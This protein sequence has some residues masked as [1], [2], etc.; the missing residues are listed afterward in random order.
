MIIFV[1]EKQ[2]LNHL[3]Y[4]LMVIKGFRLGAVVVSMLILCGLHVSARQLTEQEAMSVAGDFQ[5]S[6]GAFRHQMP[7]GA[8]PSLR[9]AYKAVDKLTSK[10]SFYVFDRGESDGFVIVSGDD[11]LRDVLGYTT[12]GSFDWDSAPEN[13]KWW[14]SQYQEEIEA[15]LSEAGSDYSPVMRSA[16][17]ATAPERTIAPLVTTRWN[18]SEPFNNM[19]PTINGRRAVTGCVATA[20]AQIIN[21]HRYPVKGIGQNS[22]T[23]DDGVN[24]SCDFSSITFDWNNMRDEYT[25]NSPATSRNAVAQLMF[26]CGASV[27]MSYG[28]NES[29]AGD[30]AVPHALCEYFGYDKGVKLLGRSQYSLSDWQQIVYDELA[31]SRPVYYSGQASNGGHAFVCDGYAGNGYFHINWGWGGLSDGDFALTA[32]N[33]NDQGIGSYQG[34]YNSSQ[35]IIVGIQPDKGNPPYI[36][37]E[38]RGTFTHYMSDYFQL[39]NIYSLY[40]NQIDVDFGVEAI[41]ATT[42][43]KVGTFNGTSSLNFRAADVATGSFYGYT[44][45]YAIIPVNGL[46]AGTYHLYPIYQVKGLSEWTNLYPAYGE[47]KYVILTVDA[48]GNK[49][50][51][52]PAAE[53]AY[54]LTITNFEVMGTAYRNTEVPIKIGVQ[55]NA[56]ADYS[57]TI[58]MKLYNSTGSEVYS[59]RL[60]ITVASG[61]TFNGTMSLSFDIA[62]G[63]YTVKFFDKGNSEIPG[64][65]MSLTIVEGSAPVEP[66][67]LF[68]S[69]LTPT[70]VYRGI[71]FAL[72][73]TFK[74][75]TNTTYKTGIYIRVLDKPTGSTL[76]QFIFNG[77]TLTAHAVINYNLSGCSVDLPADGQYQICIYD[78]SNNPLHDPIDFTVYEQAGDLW[79]GVDASKTAYV[80]P[81]LTGTYEGAIEIPATVSLDGKTFPVKG[82]GEKAF[83]GCRNLKAIVMRST[84]VPSFAGNTFTNIDPALAFYVPSA[85]YDGYNAVFGGI[86]GPVY[87]IIEDMIY[88]IDGTDPQAMKVGDRVAVNVIFKPSLHVDRTVLLT[89]DESGLFSASVKDVAADRVRI[90]MTALRVGSGSLSVTSAEPF[91]KQRFTLPVEITEAP[92]LPDNGI[93]LSKSN[94]KMIAGDSFQ[95]TATL[96]PGGEETDDIDWTSSNPDVATV[97][98]GLISALNYGRTVVTATY[99]KN[100]EIKAECTVDV[101]LVDGVESVGADAVK[102]LVSGHD[103]YVTGIADGTSVAIYSV[104][105]ARIDEMK[106]VDGTSKLTVPARG[107]YILSVSSSTFK[108]VI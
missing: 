81:S 41:S 22:Y 21:Y 108:I 83:S 92:A 103:V 46:A 24:V 6:S 27:F 25:A 33:P 2:L 49:T 18:Q 16:S 32:L 107:V 99:R 10:A 26:A 90:E 106:A 77:L 66:E 64:N 67:T 15:Y 63:T 35:S 29:S 1:S 85:A 97:N 57:G 88:T 13:M 19:C 8:V 76:R 23:T 36:P 42:G 52:N 79:Y 51:T 39:T 71:S 74:N 31:A 20:L 14:L 40:Y 3:K 43:E 104:A 37:I 78:S 94:L 102:V 100:P 80:A 48:A 47:A 69:S 45:A 105:G 54:D 93:V 9:L 28:L 44:S 62:P 91:G 65:S 87:A 34:G 68:V 58:T 56:S 89:G 53:I 72:Q 11:R 82:L 98:G 61:Q 50:F 75:N 60:G 101:S 70:A 55:N 38:L 84:D 30:V 5:K 17:R 95:L 86:A 96:Y 59:G 12:S 4:R 73:A 7:A